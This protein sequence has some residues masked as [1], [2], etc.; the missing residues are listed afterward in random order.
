MLANMH[1]KVIER[2][3]LTVSAK[4]FPPESCVPTTAQIK[5]VNQNSVFRV[6][7]SP[8]QGILTVDLPLIPT[9]LLAKPSPVAVLG[10]GSLSLRDRSSQGH[11]SKPEILC[12]CL[13]AG[14]PCGVASIGASRII[15]AQGR[16]HWRFSGMVIPFS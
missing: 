1:C 5:S 9:Q 11:Y 12:I 15:V 6:L 3:W 10:V 7:H 4:P 14:N 13:Y 2:A 8:G 16:C